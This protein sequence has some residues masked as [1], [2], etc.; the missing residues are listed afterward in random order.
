MRGGTRPRVAAATLVV[1]PGG[2]GDYTTIQAA[3]DGLPA[4]G[5]EVFVREG[6][7]AEALTIPNKHVKIRGASRVGVTITVPTNGKGIYDNFD[8]GLEV[9]HLTLQGDASATQY[10]VDFGSGVQGSFYKSFRD[11]DAWNFRTDVRV[12]AAGYAVAA[13]HHCQIQASDNAASVHWDGPGYV[14]AVRTYWLSAS[15][16]NSR[17]GWKNAADNLVWYQ[18]GGQIEYGVSGD[19]SV[20][21][22]VNVAFY[23]SSAALTPTGDRSRITGSRFRGRSTYPARYIDIPAGSDNG[24]YTGNFFEAG[25]TSEAVRNAA[26]G[27]VV[28]HNTNNVVAETGSPTSQDYGA[29]HQTP[30][31]TQVGNV[32]GGEDD[33]ITDTLAAKALQRVGASIRATF[34]GAI[35]NNANAKTFRVYFGTQVCLT[36][37]MPASVARVWCAVLEVFRTGANTQ[38]YVC[39]LNGDAT[40]VLDEEHGTAAQTDTA[41]ITVKC[42]GQATAND[43]ITQAGMRLEIF[44]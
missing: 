40:T 19:L 43:D 32:G 2:R 20:I 36:F 37:S 44:P 23:S 5:G 18:E 10:A 28:K 31:V 8:K 42:T 1:D 39:T 3:L 16:T 25:F 26:A 35:A 12:D 13:F 24:R 22:A 17:G 41:A 21:E 29:I 11:V 38:K 34:W 9:E 7:Y 30:K 33:L 6:T 4:G 27:S 15:G 14:D